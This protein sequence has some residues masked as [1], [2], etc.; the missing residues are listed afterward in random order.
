METSVNL[1]SP[2]SYSIWPIVLMGVVFIFLTILIVLLVVKRKKKREDKKTEP[3]QPVPVKRDEMDVKKE[4]LNMIETIERKYQ[5]GELSERNCYQELSRCVR[6]FVYAITGVKVTTYTL[7]EI[8][9]SKMPGL[10]KLISEY[11]HPEFAK[12]TRDEV[13]QAITEAKRVIKTWN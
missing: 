6:E 12:E 8:R 11:Y 10:E 9:K 3:I 13:E 1:Q 5:N 4:Y 2:F 7:T